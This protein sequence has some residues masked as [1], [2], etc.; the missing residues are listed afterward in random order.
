MSSQLVL[1]NPHVKLYYHSDTQIVH[2]IYYPSIGGEPLK[3]ALNTGVRLLKE[4]GA[5]KWLSDN[6]RIDSVTD[7]ETRWINTHWLPSAMA[8]GWKY[9]ALVVPQ[10]TKARMNMNEFVTEFYEQGVRVMV[11]TDADEAMTWLKNVDK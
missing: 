2:H 8:A 3:K 10:S 11:F 1:D 7:E 5:V 6:S 4:H 9:W